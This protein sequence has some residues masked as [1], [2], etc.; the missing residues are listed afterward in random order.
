MKAGEA[1]TEE[2]RKEVREKA[3]AELALKGEDK[4]SKVD[5]E[6]LK[7][8]TEYLGRFWLHA[9]LMEGPVMAN[10]VKLIV[11]TFL[12]RKEFGVEEIQEETISKVVLERGEVYCVGRDKEGCM[13]LVICV[14]K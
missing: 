14:R 3:M 7:T 8:D 9:Q 13:V 4:F 12:W 11:E 10:T 1:V 2:E 6:R 5:V